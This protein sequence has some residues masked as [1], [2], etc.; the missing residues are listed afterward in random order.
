[1]RD[2]GR[3]KS[4]S[5]SISAS[6]PESSS[7]SKSSSSGAGKSR[8]TRLPKSKTEQTSSLEEIGRELVVQ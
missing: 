3:V 2:L 4:R 5:G 8:S 7:M 1:M 6:M